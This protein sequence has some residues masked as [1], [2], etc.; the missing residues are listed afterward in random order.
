MNLNQQEP[1]EQPMTHP[2]WETPNQHLLGSE[3]THE[4]TTHVP[5]THVEAQMPAPTQN[6]T[7][8][9]ET[10]R[11]MRSGPSWHFWWLLF[12]LFILGIG[13]LIAFQVWDTG[14]IRD[15]TMQSETTLHHRVDSAI[16]GGQTRLEDRASQIE[17]RI[18]RLQ[19]I[20]NELS[21]ENATLRAKIDNTALIC[22]TSCQNQTIEK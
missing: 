15:D 20:V 10:D 3:P 6:N 16:T 13:A 14:L 12:I 1:E 21:I 4:E 5:V 2:E 11:S 9:S 8:A 18:D 7:H 19:Q 22:Q 17:M